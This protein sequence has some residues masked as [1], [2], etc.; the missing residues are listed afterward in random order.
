MIVSDI[1]TITGAPDTPPGDDD[2]T[3]DGPV[4]E[5]VSVTVGKTKKQ[6]SQLLI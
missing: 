1:S 2:H 4:D 6:D 3:D 5:T